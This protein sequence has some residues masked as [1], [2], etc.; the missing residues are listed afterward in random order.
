VGGEGAEVT[1]R[2]EGGFGSSKQRGTE[3]SWTL[4]QSPESQTPGFFYRLPYY[5]TIL[6]YYP[7]H[8]FTTPTPRGPNTAPTRI[9]W[10]PVPPGADDP[11]SFKL[12]PPPTH[13][14]PPAMRP[15][16]DGKPAGRRPHT[17]S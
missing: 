9:Q 3:G 7:I 12:R 17:A 2:A 14:H 6:L 16:P 4:R 1:V 5:I 11:S 13:G 10:R 8:L 15:S